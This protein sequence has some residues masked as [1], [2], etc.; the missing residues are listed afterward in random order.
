MTR[1]TPYRTLLLLLTSVGACALLACALLAC[2]GGGSS[3]GAPAAGPAAGAPQAA[4][5]RKLRV[6]IA[7]TSYVHAVA[8]I[9]Q[10]KGFFAKHGLDVEVVALSG[11]PPTV[12][13]L[14][15]GDL[16]LG[17]AGGDA[18][19]K[20]DLAGADIVVLASL[21]SRHYHR[22]VSRADIRTPADLKGKT[23]GL[24]VLGGP[25]DFLVHVLCQKWGLRY[26]E[27]V[28]VQVVGEEL[29]KVSAVVNGR[30]D[31]VASV[32]PSA[33]V[34]GLGLNMLADPRTWDEPAPY[35]TLLAR[36]GW[37]AENGAAVRDF[38]KALTDAQTYYLTESDAA[39]TLLA[40]KLGAGMGDARENYV[41]GGPLLYVIPPLPDLR[42]LQ[43]AFDY[44]A[45]D[46]AFRTKA[47]GFRLDGI[48]D[49]SFVDAL[50][51][52]GY[53]DAAKAAQ[54]QLAAALAPARADAAPTA[55]A[56]PAAAPEGATR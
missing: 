15:S 21:V 16:Q 37:V 44:I 26:G 19:I 7:I 40:D 20:A 56:A 39:L 5:H 36:R 23:V 35:L 41:E 43:V 25:Q 17:L 32:I 33:K 45:G 6:G 47:E 4:E 38:L 13:G 31:A 42:A 22:I 55:P 14:L 10:E 8:W 9:A 53:F 51:A 12:K 46:E 28:K 18:A 27:D 54:T 2:R 29:S 1:R 52:D 50:A 48:V 30:V 49:G 34:R 3:P 24:Q 11:S